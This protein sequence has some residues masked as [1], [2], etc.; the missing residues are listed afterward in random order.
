ML[1]DL[2][3]SVKQEDYSLT[4]TC[5]LFLSLPSSSHCDYILISGDIFPP[6]MHTH[7][8]DK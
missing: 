4:L 6:H 3:N 5:P 7:T 1:F 2:Q 8:W